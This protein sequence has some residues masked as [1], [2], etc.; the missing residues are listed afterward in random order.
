MWG[1]PYLSWLALLLI[2]GVFVLGFLD[3]DVRIQLLST[4]GLT[5]FIVIVC[6]LGLRTKKAELNAATIDADDAASR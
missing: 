3:A 1:F 4:F 6:W 5:A 2:I